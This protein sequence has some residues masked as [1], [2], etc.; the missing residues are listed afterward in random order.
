MIANIDG[1]PLFPLINYMRTVHGLPQYEAPVEHPCAN[2]YTGFDHG[3]NEFSLAAWLARAKSTCTAEVIT[4]ILRGQITTYKESCDINPLF[5]FRAYNQVNHALKAVESRKRRDE[6]MAH[7]QPFLYAFFTHSFDVDRKCL[8]S[9]RFQ[10]KK[11]AT[12]VQTNGTPKCGSLRN[13]P[14]R[15]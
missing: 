8:R 13:L 6:Q 2:D 9:K 15:E 10:G 1:V 11:Y 12:F 3:G 7:V 4:K 14:F 5:S